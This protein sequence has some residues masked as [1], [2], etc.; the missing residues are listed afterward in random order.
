MQNFHKISLILLITALFSVITISCKDGEETTEPQVS[1]LDKN[2]DEL[3][4]KI[5]LQGSPTV[6][7]SAT[8]QEAI[9]N[10]NEY[11]SAQSEIEK[12]KNSSLQ[13]FINNADIIDDAVVKIIDSIPETF[14]NRAVKSRLN[15]LNT[16]I[17]V[18]KQ[19][20]DRPNLNKEMI[21]NDATAVYNAFQDF[22]IQLNEVFLPQVSELNFD[23]DA[24]QD[25]IQR[26][27]EQ[28]L[29]DSIE[30]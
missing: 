18:M 3:S 10:W 19:D 21:N 12:I 29:P 8:T 20:L 25:S 23:I 30:R 2:A 24:R 1:Y 26:E 27:N 4:K 15:V 5:D 16:K 22:K 14:N 9:S 28:K 11:L 17:K 7:L 6:E 13:N